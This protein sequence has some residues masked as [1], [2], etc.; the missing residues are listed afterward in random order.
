MIWHAIV[1][2]L[3]V[4]GALL[5]LE[6]GFLVALELSDRLTHRRNA[7]KANLSLARRSWW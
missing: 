7:A 1:N 5:L 6:V 4:F 2:V 3:A